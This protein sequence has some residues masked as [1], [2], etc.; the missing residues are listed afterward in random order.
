MKQRRWLT[1]LRWLFVLP[2]ALLGF[3]ASVV[4]SFPLSMLI[5]YVLPGV[6]QHPYDLTLD[7]ALAASLTIQFGAYAAPR[8]KGLVALFLLALGG[9]IAWQL[10]GEFY[11]PMHGFH[12]ETTRTWWPITGT[13]LGGVV[14]CAWIWLGSRPK[15]NVGSTSAAQPA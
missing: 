15:R 4:L 11:W 10:V 13:Y 7:G 8:H 12:N 14:T 1:I 6:A 2:A 5:P 9:I 3:C